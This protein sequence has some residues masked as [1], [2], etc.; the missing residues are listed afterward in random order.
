MSGDN[1]DDIIE[2]IE[3]EN[4]HR[5]EVEI[6]KITKKYG[7]SEGLMECH[8]CSRRQ[9]AANQWHPIGLGT[10]ICQTCRAEVDKACCN[11]LWNFETLS[12]LAGIRAGGAPT[13]NPIAVAV[14]PMPFGSFRP[15]KNIK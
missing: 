1:I 12:R 6:A 10:F 3:A 2:S 4:Q 8:T 15:R 5:H 13:G 9:P 14:I 7:F 11:G